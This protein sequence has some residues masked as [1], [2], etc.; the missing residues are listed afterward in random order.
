MNSATLLAVGADELLADGSR[1]AS[2]GFDVVCV[3]GVA[4]AR[5]RLDAGGV[6]CVLSA[7]TLADGDCPALVRA[8]RDRTADADLPVVLWTE[9]ADPSVV[10]AAV[11]AGATDCVVSVDGVGTPLLVRRLRDAVESHRARR[12]EMENERA[13]AAR[14]D[15][16][17]FFNSLLRHEVLNGLAVITGYAEL[18]DSTT[19]TETERTRYV[20]IIR[21][22]G[23]DLVDVVQR[24]RRVLDELTTEPTALEERDLVAVVRDRLEQVRLSHPDAVVETSLPE[25]ATVHADD[26]L[27]EVVYNLL[28][29][30]V[31]H[32][33]RERPRL[34][35]SASVTLAATTLRVADDGPGFVDGERTV[36][37]DQPPTLDA[38]GGFGL[39]FVATMA[40][41]YGARAVAEPNDPRGTVVSLEFPTGP[42]DRGD[43]VDGVEEP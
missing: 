24:I 35:V 6:D 21:E 13:L 12:R 9:T 16:I 7:W 42:A 19:V 1:F 43:G 5:T 3:E 38:D 26:L 22:R 8:V 14:H 40:R 29:N 23:T 27:G 15:Q 17:A 34:S 11:D 28:S 25:T 31:E 30:A 2:E 39:Y 33:D 10:A 32:N 37:T 41:K 20:R 4:G 18:M 36:L